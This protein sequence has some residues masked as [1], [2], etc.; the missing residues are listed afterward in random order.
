MN[1]NTNEHRRFGSIDDLMK[2]KKERFIP[3]P[4]SLEE[5][6]NRMLGKKKSVV[7]SKT[8]GGKL[9]KWAAKKRNRRASLKSSGVGQVDDRVTSYAIEVSMGKIPAGLAQRQACER[10]LQDLE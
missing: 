5:A 4:Q 3:V 8:S 7:V 10:H 9:S 6:A 1:P 2:G